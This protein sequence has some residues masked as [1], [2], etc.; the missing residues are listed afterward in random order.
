MSDKFGKDIKI[1][2]LLLKN[3][4][5]L[6]DKE[7]RLVLSWRNHETV[8]KYVATTPDEISM[9]E[10]GAFIEKL[11]DRKD[12]YYYMVKEQESSFGVISLFDVDF[13]N[14]RCMWGLYANTDNFNTGTGIILEYAALY[15]VFDVLG[16]HCLRCEINEEN[17]RALKLFDL[18]G[19]R[20]EG[21]LHDYIY[22]DREKRYYNMV[23]MSILKEQ[24]ETKRSGIE[25][26][27]R[28][29]LKD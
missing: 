3:F 21:I 9:E 2:R 27:L 6:T 17:S 22:R 15:M 20:R 28:S 14:R 7:K 5:N 26:M 12:R 16:L 29:F 23:I 25:S 18:V 8:R 11:R 19:F 24:W 13:Y 4:I 10:H 1:G